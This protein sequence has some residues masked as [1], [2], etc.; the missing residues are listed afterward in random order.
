MEVDGLFY[1]WFMKMSKASQTACKR[2]QIFHEIFE[3]PDL[4]NEGFH[5]LYVDLI[6]SHLRNQLPPLPFEAL[7]FFFHSSAKLT[8][9]Q[10][11]PDVF[12]SSLTEGRKRKINGGTQTENKRQT[13]IKSR[14]S[15]FWFFVS[16]FFAMFWRKEK[17]RKTLSKMIVFQHRCRQE[18]LSGE[19]P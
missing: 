11:L 9:R 13:Q 6:P 3:V 12:Y 1:F 16:F 19:I 17:S 2:K 14:L 18:G 8:T 5:E 10:K 15:I 4:H 7:R